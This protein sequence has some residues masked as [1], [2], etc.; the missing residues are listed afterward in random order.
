MNEDYYFLPITT[1]APAAASAIHGFAHEL[2]S[3]GSG[4]RVILDALA[5][6]AECGLGQVYAAA[7]YLTQM[8]REGQA[9]AAPHIAAALSLSPMCSER[10]TDTIS[11]IAAWG[12]GD[13][14]GAILM[15]RRVVEIT[16]QDL[17]AAKLCQILELGAGD[18]SG[19]V[20][21][22]AMVAAVE[23]RSGYALGLH[24]FALEQAGY[25]EVALRFA[26]RALDF[27][28]VC[29]PWAQ[30]A[31]AHAL[32]AM[33]QPIEARAFLRSVAPSWARCSSFMLTH[34][35]WHLA[36]LELDLGNRGAAFAIFD[37]HVWGVRKGHVQDQINAISLLIRLEM[38][39]ACPGWR[40]N[41]IATYGENRL[42][43]R[44]S[45]FIDLHYLIALVRSGR[46]E[47]ASCLCE[48]LQRERV[49]GA[50]AQAIVAHARDDFSVA[51][52]SIAS[53]R[54]KIGEIGGSNVQRDLFEVIFID[55]IEQVRRA[56]SFVNLDDYRVAA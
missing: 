34:N 2:V 5:A 53:V 8:T 15:L 38:Q 36:L 41:D 44:M 32:I 29:D 4:A 10:E 55:C 9:Q 37:E 33:D 48:A 23:G 21:T 22:S 16:P 39:G 3:H 51:A 52:S 19:M 43:D 42:S 31:V 25:P 27:N 54:R 24:A 1:I 45:D 12:Q 56:P 50:L 6:D 46:N 49:A 11:A 18:V 7:L 30:H 20:R 47:A 17:V 28:P 40:W 14:R 13:N 26:R 35:W